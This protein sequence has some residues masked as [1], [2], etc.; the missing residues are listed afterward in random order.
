MPYFGFD[1]GGLNVF[2]LRTKCKIKPTLEISDVVCTKI[3][4]ELAAF[5]GH[6]S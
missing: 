4:G 5:R 1:L 3:N 2:F 6:V